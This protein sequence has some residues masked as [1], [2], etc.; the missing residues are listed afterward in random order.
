MPWT[1][2]PDARTALRVVRN[3]SQ[4]NARVLVD[5]LH[6]ARSATTLSDIAALPPEYLGYAQMCDAPGE[7][8]T[9]EAGL[10]HTA[11]QARLLPG[12]G[13]LDLVGIFAQLPSSLPISIEVPNSESSVALGVETWAVQAL[14]RTRAVLARRHRAHAM[15]ASLRGTTPRLR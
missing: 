5:A 7:T 15:G 10:I 13:D 14:A 8:P 1:T 4:R 12:D 9:T 11:R 2:V 3:A 6:A